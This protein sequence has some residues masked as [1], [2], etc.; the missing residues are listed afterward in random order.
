MDPRTVRLS[1]K[2]TTMP[3]YRDEFLWNL[4]NIFRYFHWNHFYLENLAVT[5]R[6]EMR[7]VDHRHQHQFSIHWNGFRKSIGL[8]WDL[9]GIHGPKPYGTKRLGP[10]L[11]PKNSDI[12][13]RLRPGP[14]TSYKTQTDSVRRSMGPVCTN[15]PNGC[16]QFMLLANFLYSCIKGAIND[17]KTTQSENTCKLRTPNETQR[18]SSMMLEYWPQG[19]IFIGNFFKNAAW[20]LSKTFTFPRCLRPVSV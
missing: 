12:Q 11:G 19:M 17:E 6:S 18:T 15:L 8:V 10:V 4:G 5:I 1:P 7:R 3:W 20:W 9:E 14:Y 2:N 13:H 16:N